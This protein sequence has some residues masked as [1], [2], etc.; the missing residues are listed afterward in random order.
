MKA[1]TIRKLPPDVTRAIRKRAQEKK[2]SINKAVVSLLEEAVSGPARKPK[3]VHHDLD[4]L[5]GSWTAAE[6][7]RFNRAIAEQRKI[8]PEM[9]GR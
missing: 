1:V 8:D 3:Q 2:L 7:K 6:A 5:V 9:W 4:F